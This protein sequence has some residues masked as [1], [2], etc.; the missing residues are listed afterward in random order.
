MLMLF[1]TNMLDQAYGSVLL[2]L[3][4]HNIYG[5]ALG[6]GLL[7]A[8]MGVGAILTNIVYTALAPKLPRW[9]PYTFGFIIAGAPRFFVLG[10]GSPIWLAMATAFATGV[11]VAALN[12]IL[13]AVMYERVPM[14][15]QS[16]VNG[17][18]TALAY[19]GMPIGALLGGWVGGI[20]TRFGLFLTGA[21]YL[22][23]TLA[24]LFGRFWHEMDVRPAAVVAAQRESESEGDF[25]MNYTE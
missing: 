8:A 3:W 2:P 18:G 11:G 10:F 16:R 1:V 14:R 15:L 4:A 9:A 13:S 24:P 12:P 20:G 7:A 23:A 6:I 25:V 19:A 21:L 5:S 22:L 17:L